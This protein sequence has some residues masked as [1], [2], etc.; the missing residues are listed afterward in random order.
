MIPDLSD[1]YLVISLPPTWT[2]FICD[3]EEKE[4]FNIAELSL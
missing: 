1:S 2:I 3:P 4:P